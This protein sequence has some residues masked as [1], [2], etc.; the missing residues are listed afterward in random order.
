M[1]TRKRP[2]LA[3]DINRN[4]GLRG[5][6]ESAV[7]VSA[8]AGMRIEGGNIESVWAIAWT[9]P[10][11]VTLDTTKVCTVACLPGHRAGQGSE[12]D[13]AQP[14]GSHSK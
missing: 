14:F 6:R 10:S 2:F 1:Y 9:C 3:A 8:L 5:I 7:P 11:A 12:L 4:T 13:L